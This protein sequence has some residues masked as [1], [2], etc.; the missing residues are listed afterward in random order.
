MYTV[1][2][3][4]W[5]VWWGTPALSRLMFSTLRNSEP[6]ELPVED[7][8]RC[9]SVDRCISADRSR[10]AIVGDSLDGV[11]DADVMIN[12]CY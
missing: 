3:S 4:G 12:Y 11:I 10:L 9:I 8:P 5:G 2:V 6:V 1:L 7:A